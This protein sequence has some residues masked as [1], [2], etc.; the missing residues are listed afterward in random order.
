MDWIRRFRIKAVVLAMAATVLSIPL[1]RQ[2]VAGSTQSA[3]FLYTWSGILLSR[4][5][6]AVSNGSWEI[7]SRLSS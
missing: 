3:N 5:N 1:F 2:S 4:F 7:D 6:Y